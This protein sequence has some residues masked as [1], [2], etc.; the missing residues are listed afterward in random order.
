[1]NNRENL[2]PSLPDQIV[3]LVVEDEVTV[4]NVVRI[5]LEAEGYFILTAT[6][7]EQALFMSRQYSG[8]IHAVL[9][10]VIMPNMDGLELRNRISLERPGIKILLMSG[11]THHV[12]EN[13]PFLL[14]PFTPAVLKDRMRTLLRGS[15]TFT[16]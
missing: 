13:I 4:R 11:M 9:S 14:K 10:D 2:L 7:G 8:K 1:M 5:T 3:I 12:A 16:A 15:A 6:D